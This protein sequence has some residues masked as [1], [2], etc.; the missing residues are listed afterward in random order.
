MRR[1][2][3]AV[4]SSTS[5]ASLGRPWL[6][7]RPARVQVGALRVSRPWR[8]LPAKCGRRRLHVLQADPTQLREAT[9]RMRLLTFIR[10]NRVRSCARAESPPKTTVIRQR[11]KSVSSASG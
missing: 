1:A 5:R 7:A 4:A 3:F 9:M 11:T 10:S 8:D 6:K 2:E